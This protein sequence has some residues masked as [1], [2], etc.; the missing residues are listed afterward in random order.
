[1]TSQSN[2]NRFIFILGYTSLK[3]KI[4]EIL[5]GLEGSAWSEKR[6]KDITVVASG[7]KQV[8]IDTLAEKS[9]CSGCLHLTNTATS[10]DQNPTMTHCCFK[11]L[12]ES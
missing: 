10:L 7:P 6:N 9:S 3:S 8:Y 11:V 2:N 12:M 1:M 5:L 4:H